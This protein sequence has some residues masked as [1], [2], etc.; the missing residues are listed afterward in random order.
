MK[1]NKWTYPGSKWQ[2]FDFH[3]HTPASDNYG[4]GDESLKKIHPEEWLR[5]AMESGLD[6]VVVADHNAGGWIDKLKAKNREI[7][8]KDVKPGWYRDLTIFPGV[9]IT[10]ADSSRVHLLAVFDPSCDSQ[11]VTG[12]LGSCGITTGFGDDTKT[13]T[14][15]GFV[16][17]VKKSLKQAVL[18]SLRTLTDQKDCLKALPH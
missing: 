9:E 18:L 2:K 8:N 13:S 16:A 15:T 14:S 17:T 5:K 6:C 4:H 1:D 12:V 7:Q 3:T 11:T 10:V